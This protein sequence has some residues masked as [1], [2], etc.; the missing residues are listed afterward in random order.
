MTIGELIAIL[1]RLNPEQ[2]IKH[3]VEYDYH[4]IC[5]VVQI[6]EKDGTEYHVIK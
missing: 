4:N 1:D 2:V 5:E 3:D 6:I